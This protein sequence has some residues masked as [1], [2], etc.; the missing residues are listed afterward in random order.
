MSDPLSVEWVFLWKILAKDLQFCEKFSQSPSVECFLCFPS[1]FF[2]RLHFN[3]QCV[4]SKLENWNWAPPTD[5]SSASRHPEP[6]AYESWKWSD[7]EQTLYYPAWIIV[8][9]Y[10]PYCFCLEIFR[11]RR[12]IAHQ[13]QKDTR[14]ISDREIPRLVQSFEAKRQPPACP[15]A[16]MDPT[17]L[18][19]RNLILDFAW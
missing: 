8:I 7:K 13:F 15:I 19:L 5:K 12:K 2:S 9:D 3:V 4:N 16:K 11:T 14:W 18:W 1:P 10:L 17:Y 6:R